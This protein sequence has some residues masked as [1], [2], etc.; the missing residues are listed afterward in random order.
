MKIQ[1]MGD[2]CDY[3]SEIVKPENNT[4]SNNRTGVK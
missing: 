1:E 4:Y 2:T 3:F